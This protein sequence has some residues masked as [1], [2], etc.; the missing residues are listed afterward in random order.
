MVNHIILT[1]FGQRFVSMWYD[2]VNEYNF[3]SAGFNKKTGHFTQVVWVNTMDLGCGLAISE[4]K[5]V[6]AVSNYS[7]PGNLDSIKAFEK[8]VLPPNV[9]F[10]KY[11]LF[12]LLSIF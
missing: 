7:P 9:T 8:N 1:D 6:F 12:K 2:E 10:M 4:N 5:K 11:L 3:S